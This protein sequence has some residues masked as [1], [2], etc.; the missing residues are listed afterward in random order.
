LCPHFQVTTAAVTALPQGPC[1]NPDHHPR[2]LRRLDGGLPPRPEPGRCG[3]GGHPSGQP[4]WAPPPPCLDLRLQR[5]GWSTRTAAAT[6]I[7]GEVWCA[8]QCRAALEPRGPRLVS[9]PHG[10]MARSRHHVTA[11]PPSLGP[12]EELSERSCRSGVF[13]AALSE[14]RCRSG[15]VGAPVQAGGGVVGANTVVALSR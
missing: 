13:G 6:R 14:R 8:C 15:A 1:A 10:R 9:G 7:A 4:P 5:L 11:D 12:A 2:P 3:P